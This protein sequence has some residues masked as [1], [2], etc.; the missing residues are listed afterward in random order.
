MRIDED[1]LKNILPETWTHVNNLNGLQ[2]GFSLK[3]LGVDWRSENVFGKIML[4]LERIGLLLREGMT[5]RRNP[6]SSF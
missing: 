3:L 1:K 4:F 5:V 6:H 2:L